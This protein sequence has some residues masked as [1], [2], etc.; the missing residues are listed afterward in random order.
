[1]KTS[2]NKQCFI[3]N[4]FTVISTLWILKVFLWSLPYKFSNH[5]D[6]RHI[7]STIWEWIS[8]T[9]NQNIGQGFSNYGWYVIGALEL[10]VSLV[11]LFA[12]FVLIIKLFWFLKKTQTPNYLFAIGWFWAMIMMMGAIF[13]HTQTP[14]WIEVIHEWKSDGGSLFKA[15]VSVF[16][17]WMI[18]FIAY[19]K[20]L[21]EKFSK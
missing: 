14:L 17:L 12:V 7:F 1:M 20:S 16:F 10:M 9:V 2:C 3:L 19:F 18:M 11:L 15:A 8:A 4:F 5:P 6:T 13:F 21:K